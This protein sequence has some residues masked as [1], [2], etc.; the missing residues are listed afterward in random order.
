MRTAGAALAAGA[1]A[2]ACSRE[3][4]DQSGREIRKTA[5][6]RIDQAVALKGCLEAS[7]EAGE[8][9]LRYVQLEPV[10]TQP[11]DAPTSV[12]VTVTEGSYVRLRMNDSDELKQHLGQRV[13]VSGTIIDDGRS[14]IGT[15]GRPRD[16]DEAEPPTDASRAG[17][18]EDYS[19]K[20]Q[21]EAGP[22]G[23]DSLSNGTVPRMAVEKVTGSG[24]RCGKS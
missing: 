12:G 10:S 14:T 20:Q 11:T 23:Q 24:E 1:V 4:D 17:A 5:G 6:G 3:V 15:G 16:P 18:R 7:P 19:R 8:Y 22:L 9:V 2:A 21:K 13:S